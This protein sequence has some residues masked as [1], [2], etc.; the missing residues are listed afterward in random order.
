MNKAIQRMFNYMIR[1][2]NEK[3]SWRECFSGFCGKVME[4]V[5]AERG[6]ALIEYLPCSEKVKGICEQRHEN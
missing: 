5:A 3:K 6:P 1:E 2:G 4:H